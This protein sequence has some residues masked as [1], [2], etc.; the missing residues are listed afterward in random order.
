[1][2]K[3]FKTIAE[4]DRYK[5]EELVN[6]M[7][8]EGWEIK[9]CEIHPILESSK[10]NQNEDYHYQVIWTAFMYRE[11]VMK[12]YKRTTNFISQEDKEFYC[13]CWYC[14]ESGIEKPVWIECERNS[15]KGFPH[16]EYFSNKEECWKRYERKT[17]PDIDNKVIHPYRF[18][19]TPENIE[20][21][22][23]WCN[24]SIK[25]MKLPIEKRCID[26]QT[27]AGEIRAEMWEWIVKDTLGCFRVFKFLER[28]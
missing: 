13:P 2:I 15:L 27:P 10:N 24:G 4:Y 1:M 17:N 23:Q 14:Q 25:G 22:A 3:E 5:Y 19:L 20:Q 9:S 8:G 18:Q 16:C 21:V 11:R 26:F 12:P 6:K 28:L 7:L